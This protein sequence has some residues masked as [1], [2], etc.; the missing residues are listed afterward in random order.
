MIPAPRT[1]GALVSVSFQGWELRE[2]ADE[3]GVDPD[4]VAGRIAAVAAQDPGT[5]GWLHGRLEA[6]WGPSEPTPVGLLAHELQQARGAGDLTTVIQLL[7]RACGTPGVAARQLE[8]KA[9]GILHRQALARWVALDVQE[10]A[11]K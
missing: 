2:L 4:Q 10:L 7:W 11:A 1:L 8:A 6:R 5:W 3:Y 9:L